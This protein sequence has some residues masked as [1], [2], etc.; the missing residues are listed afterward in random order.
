MLAHNH[1]RHSQEDVDDGASSTVITNSLGP[2]SI[3]EKLAQGAKEAW[4]QFTSRSAGKIEET[5]TSLYQA[6][7][8]GVPAAR[9]SFSGISSN[10]ILQIFSGIN[11]LVDMMDDP[12]RLMDAVELLGFQH[13][14]LTITE[15]HV[16]QFGDAVLGLVVKNNRSHG[17]QVSG[18]ARQGLAMLMKYVGG[19]IIYVRTQNAAK[20]LEV[21][22]TS[23][24]IANADAIG[25][26]GDEA[27]MGTT[28]GSSFEGSGSMSFSLSDASGSS[29][30]KGDG[31][32]EGFTIPQSFEGMFQLHAGVMGFNAER[33]MGEVTYHLDAIIRNASNKGRRQEE[34]DVLSLRLA[35]Y[36]GSVV[37]LANYK[38]CLFA[39]LRSV[40]PKQWTPEHERAWTWLWDNLARLL[41]REFGKPQLYERALMKWFDDLQEDDAAEL[42][43]NVYTKFF[44]QAPVGQEYLKQS[45][46]RL[47]FIAESIFYMVLKLYQHP[48]KMVQEISALGLRHVGFGIPPD[49]LLPFLTACTETVLERTQDRTLIDGFRCSLSLIT[50][51]LIRVISE[52]STVV[53]KAINANSVRMV[54]DA[55]AA[56]P[57]GS[58]AMQLLLVQV[59]TQSISPLSWVIESGSI[60]VARAMIC[61]LLTIRADRQKYYY[62]VNDL[63]KRHPDIVKRLSQEAPMLLPT[64][65]DHLVWTSHRTKHNLRRVNYFI[66]HLLIGH[67]G[68]FADALEHITAGGDPKIMGNSIV[69]VIS[70]VLWCGI[71]RK[72]FILSKVWAICSLVVFMMCQGVLPRFEASGTLERI[73]NVVMFLGKLFT[74]TVGMGQLA[75]SNFMILYRWTRRELKR[76]FD[77]IDQDGSGNIDWEEFIQAMTTFKALVKDK[78]SAA[79][80]ALRDE[81]H[82][83]SN[84]DVD[85]VNVQNKSMSKIID[86]FLFATLVLMC[87]HEPMLH[88]ANEEDFPTNT[89]RAAD[90]HLYG[91]SV[92]VMLAMAVHWLV[93]IDLAVFSTEI[94]AFLLVIGNVMKELRQFLIALGFLLFMF[95]SSIS[96][97][98]R[99]CTSDGGEFGDMFHGFITLFAITVR[100]YQG[101]YRDIQENPMLLAT[102]LLCT[103]FSA[104][105]LLNL[106]VAQLN[107]SYEYIYRDMLGFARL[108]RACVICDA[109]D[110][111]SRRSWNKFHKGLR[112]DNRREFDEGDLGLAGC[113]QQLEAASLHRVTEEKIKRYGGSTN[114]TDPW[115][116]DEE[117][118]ALPD[119]SHHCFRLEAIIN[120]ALKRIK[121]SEDTNSMAGSGGLHGDEGG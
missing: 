41:T 51:M 46:T 37:R 40:L 116:P 35:K 20:Y 19:A 80:R 17:K 112:F 11:D 114:E 48:V 95:S 1:R 3:P 88:C 50:K 62:G 113:I 83:A 87:S 29:T 39:A 70:E 24:E 68:G 59:G 22:T 44:K 43:M 109:M 26:I 47:H 58:R 5:A 67:R 101:D 7:F 120:K 105:L 32:D 23:W 30:G 72:Q 8:D 115:P 53:M 21:L 102:V 65:F 90:D 14:G 103:T 55:M 74:Y 82:V 106:L 98:C 92:F 79:I 57:R 4:S 9:N 76:I 99:N 64:L 42:R 52:G 69:V 104:V 78:I 108:N 49:L 15:Q 18:D 118:E 34:V 121:T 45:N 31:A 91:Y 73:I 27:G 33:W 12:G 13:M 81:G 110:V 38:Q 36:D 71:V 86:F 94:A 85:T 96:I 111:C 61:D 63:F 66:E 60:D 16:T 107:L 84:A 119:E 25:G 2:A 28:A 75:Y 117:E 77:E 89:C 10:Q 100:L 54:K 97:L 56:A 6:I 93:L